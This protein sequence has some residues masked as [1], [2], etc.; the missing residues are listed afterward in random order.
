MP[1][2]T[3]AA[4]TASLAV[5]VTEVSGAI[6]AIGK[7]PGQVRLSAEGSDTA[8]FVAVTVPVF[9]TTMSNV[10]ISPATEKFGVVGVL[11]TASEAL[12]GSTGTETAL[13]ADGATGTLL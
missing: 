11:V 9:S 5:H 12:N 2:V 3:S 7:P 4:E 6:A 1:A 13:G 8:T 10:T